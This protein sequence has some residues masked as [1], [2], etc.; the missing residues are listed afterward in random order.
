[1]EGYPNVLLEAMAVGLPVI[2]TDCKWGP[3]EILA[4]NT[5]YPS[6]LVNVEKAENGLLVPVN[7]VAP[8][9][10]AMQLLMDDPGCY[11]HYQNRA[12]Q[13]IQEFEESKTLSAFAAIIASLLP[14]D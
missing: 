2:A 8:L 4:P 5:V 9:A 12:K 6:Q 13:C 10:N 7:Q 1:V 14:V 3:R 11:Q